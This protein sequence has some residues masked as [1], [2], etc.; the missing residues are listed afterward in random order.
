MAARSAASRPSGLSTSAT[1]C[2]S[3]S[4]GNRRS[5]WKTT[6]TLC[7]CGCPATIGSPSSVTRPR[8]AGSR[9]PT[10]RSS[11]VLPQPLGPRRQTNSPAS[12]VNETRSITG[13]RKSLPSSS[14][15]SFTI[16]AGLERPART[17]GGSLPPGD[18][19]R[20]RIEDDLVGGHHDED[21]HQR[22]HEDHLGGQDLPD[23]A[24][25]VADPRGHAED[26]GHHGNLEGQAE[27]DLH[28]GDQVG[29]RRRHH[30]RAELLSTREKVGYAHL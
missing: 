15:V 20:E 8:V 30:D 9:P 29:Q 26:L 23:V 24:H 11:V 21:H 19:A 3:V 6:P 14:T 25:D 27:A 22:P 13:I 28:P 17:E 18:T 2:S 4:H 7:W 16:V 1:F 12:T 5:S 10:I